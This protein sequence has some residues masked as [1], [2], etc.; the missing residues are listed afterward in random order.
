VRF[1]GEIAR[2]EI[3]RDEMARAMNVEMAQKSRPFSRS[4]ASNTLPSIW[5]ATARDR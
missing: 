4:S 3:A 2:I 5:K 1:H